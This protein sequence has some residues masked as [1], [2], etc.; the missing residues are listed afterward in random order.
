MPLDA[1]SQGEVRKLIDALF[2]LPPDGSVVISETPVLG[3]HVDSEVANVRHLIV[4]LIDDPRVAV[5]KLVER[6]VSLLN[7]YRRVDVDRQR[8][9][10]EVLDI[11]SPLASRLGIPQIKWVL[12][13]LAFRVL[14][15]NLYRAI[16]G[17]L[18]E[19]R[20]VREQNVN[21]IAD[22]LQWRLGQS[23]IDAQVSGRA[24][25]IYGIWLK[26]LKKRIRFNDV[27]DTDAVRVLVETVPDCYAVLGVV[28]T[29]WPH[30]RSE[31]DDYIAAPKENGYQS[32]HTTVIGPR[33]RTLEVQIRTHEM[34]E[35]SEMG[36][37]AHWAYKGDD[38]DALRSSKGG[39]VPTGAALARSAAEWRRSDW[40]RAARRVSGPHIRHNASGPCRG[41]RCQCH[42]G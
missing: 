35:Q 25:H 33:G 21:A 42:S 8:V 26:M 4:N 12:E 11:Y 18:K 22:D 23:G 16:A 30:I 2:R 5:I 7:A 38:K 39:L 29:S 24:K 20:Q 9:A 31:F 41:S 6:I 14:Q 27:Y 3:K 1:V 36:V 17:R 19:R 15:E 34:H 32:I 13:D 10:Q 40:V 28:H 37:C